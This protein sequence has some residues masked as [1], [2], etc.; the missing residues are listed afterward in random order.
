MSVVERVR[1]AIYVDSSAIEVQQIRLTNGE[2][3]WCTRVANKKESP[4]S[5]MSTVHSCR[6][7]CGK[8]SKSSRRDIDLIHFA[9]SS[10]PRD[11]IHA[12]DTFFEVDKIA[13]CLLSVGRKNEIA[14]GFLI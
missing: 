10:D 5:V 4:G 1:F 11:L 9:V 3:R 12:S 7:G 14:T 2:Y 8:L 13:C 6:R